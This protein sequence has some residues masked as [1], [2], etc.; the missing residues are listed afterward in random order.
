MANEISWANLETD[1]GLAHYLMAGIHEDLYDPTD[2]RAVCTR[3]EWRDNMGSETAKVTRIDAAHEFAAA[4][5]E[6]LGGA[7]N[8][9][10]GTANF[11]FNPTR[12]TQ[13]WQVSD[14]WRKCAVG[15]SIDLDLLASI[16]VRGTGLTFTDMLCA[17]FPSL[18]VTAGSQTAQMS[19]DYA[20]DA[21][22]KLNNARAVGPFSLILFPHC[23]NKFQDSLRGEGGATQWLPATAAMIEAKGPG[24]KGVWNGIDVWDSDHVESDGGSTYKRNAMISQGC[25]EYVEAPA[26]DVS[27]AVAPNVI[28][29]VDGLV[30][31]V[32]SYSSET[33]LTTIDADYYPSV[34][35]AEDARGVLLYA[36][37]A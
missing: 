18:S 28:T 1:A 21:Q 9:N 10:L 20:Y 11:T 15:G 2:L 37:A 14:L 31:M 17:L 27:D 7:S 35:E 36:L 33:T 25:F 12:R 6:I 24:F 16:I 34:V 3:R 13:K 22:Y 19:V 30:R 4:S 32:R 8:E 29:I 26:V 5:T 23:F